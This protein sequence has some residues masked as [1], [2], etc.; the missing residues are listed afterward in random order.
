MSSTRCSSV[1]HVTDCPESES[2]FRRDTFLSSKPS[3]PAMKTAWLR[4][5]S[6]SKATSEQ[7]EL[8]LY[9]S[10]TSSWRGH[11]RVKLTFLHLSCLVMI[12]EIIDKMQQTR[13]SRHVKCTSQPV[14]SAM[15]RRCWTRLWAVRPRNS[16]R[17]TGSRKRRFFLLQNVRTNSGGQATFHYLGIGEFW[18]LT[19]N[20]L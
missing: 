10:Y 7:V 14:V 9:S 15:C 3:R 6:R 11:V 5:L 13:H 16:D 20:T 2:S 12:Y 19:L 1:C 4:I 17:I 18:H 8:Y